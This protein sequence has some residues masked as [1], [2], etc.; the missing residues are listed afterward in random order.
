MEVPNDDTS[1]THDGDADN[2]GISKSSS[3]SEPTKA[4]ATLKMGPDPT[5]PNYKPDGKTTVN[6]NNYV[7]SQKFKLLQQKAV[8]WVGGAVS[9]LLF[10]CAF[11]FADSGISYVVGHSESL[12]KSIDVIVENKKEKSVSISD[13]QVKLI[14]ESIS[15]L[16]TI[17][18]T[19]FIALVGIFS[20][21]ALTMSIA[22]IRN[23]HSNESKDSGDNSLQ[24]PAQQI[25]I[26]LFDAIKK[27]FGRG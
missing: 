14:S 9:L 13:N 25:F 5:D 23:A 15:K 6:F 1:R 2:D 3:G 21:I 8:F 12:L 10:V 27:V 19:F 16:Y 11:C 17:T 18:V 4:P 22:L 7:E 20:G 24:V 26:E